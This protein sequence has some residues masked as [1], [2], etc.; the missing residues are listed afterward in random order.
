MQ[1]AHVEKVAELYA[2]FITELH[3]ERPP[4]K[5]GEL[6]SFLVFLPGKREARDE[7]G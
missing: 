6:E 7:H 3:S 1:Y 2:E 5:D 4:R